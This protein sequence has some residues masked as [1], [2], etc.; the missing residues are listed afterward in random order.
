MADPALKPRCALGGHAPETHL[1][2][3][4][5]IAENPA[6][7]MASLAT[8]S[9]R[10]KEVAKAAKNLLGFDL[11]G[12]GG[13]AAAGDWAAFWTSPGQWMLT[14]PFASHEDIA[15]IVKA[16][17]ADAGSVTEQTDGWVRFEVA[18]VQVL[19][20]LERLCNADTRAMPA[21]QATR[22]QIEHLG[23]FLLCQR[24]REAFSL[25]TLRSGAASMMHALV[26]AANSLP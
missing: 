19:D 26:T 3:G 8:R 25:I 17:V 5:T 13:M 18:G 1:I 21:G 23:T 10:D 20:V 14:A 4:I 16:A 15:R 6:L 12:P 11:P 24:A 22:C 9:G 7:A 2:A